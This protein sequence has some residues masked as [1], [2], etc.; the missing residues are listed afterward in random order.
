MSMRTTRRT[1]A[2][3]VVAA[4]TMMTGCSSA[5]DGEQSVGEGFSY[6]ADQSVVDDAIADLDPV[7]LTYQPT[8]ASP[9]L[10]SAA[11]ALA[12]AEAVEERSGGKITMDMVWGQSIAPYG[13]VHDALTDGRLDIAFDVPLYLS[14]QYPVFNSALSVSQ[15]GSGSSIV[16]ETA[17]TAMMIE[18]AWESE[19][20]IEEFEGQGLDVLAPVITAGQYYFSCTQNMESLSDWEG[21]QV[22]I[23]TARQ[24]EVMESVNA[25]PVFMEYTE[26]YEA[27]ERGALDC[28]LAPLTAIGAFGLSQ[29][30][31]HFYYWDQ[32]SPADAGQGAHLAG[33]GVQ[34][35]P[36]AYRQIIF[37]AFAEYF[38]GQM[39]G[40]SDSAAISATHA[41]ESGGSVAPLPAEVEDA[42]NGAQRRGFEEL[43]DDGEVPA[44]ALERAAELTSKWEQATADS[45]VQDGGDF[46]TVDEWYDPGDLDFMPLGQEI[47]ED[48]MID[49]RPQ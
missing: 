6:G 21:A 32:Q 45:G 12:F 16:S 41:K 14:D 4:T 37:D 31:P 13:E 49:H 40:I 46:S 35:L 8:A 10:P 3:T 44:D 33:T 39:T 36:L 22:R 34:E 27:L 48:V 25:A 18:L 28:V 5:P 38:H 20:I 9:E 7:E 11:S 47:Y 30:A 15:V 43:V 29:V 2:V 26:A 1:I 42:M 19:E 24:R 17:V 23:A